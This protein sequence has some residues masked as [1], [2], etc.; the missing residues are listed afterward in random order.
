MSSAGAKKEMEMD[1]YE[2]YRLTRIVNGCGKMTKLAGAIVLPEIREVVNAAMAGFFDIEEV[3]A[4]AGEVIAKAT[5]AEWGCVTAC[6]AS[7][8]A[9][10]VAAAM[11][12][13]DAGRVAQL[14]DATGMKN[15]VVLQKGH[16]VNFGAPITQ[17]VRLAGAEAVEVG[18]VNGASE[19]LISHA[20]DDQTAAVLFVVSHHTVQFGC[21]PL[22]R[23]VALAHERGVPVIVD[24]AAQS[25]LI[26]EIVATGADLVI[27]S[28]HKYLSGTTAGIVCGR[29]DLVSAVNLQNRGIG[30][31]MKVGKEG[32][33]G[34]IAALEYRMRLDV[35]GWQ[36][37]QDRKMRM[38][39][40][41]LAGIEGVSLSVA[42]DPN[43]NP[44]SRARVDVDPVR[45][46]LSAEA[47]SRA[48]ADGDP[49]IH[50]R[51]HHT[52]E[53]FFMVDTIEMT[54]DEVDLTC[55]RLRSILTASDKT[56]LMTRYGGDASPDARAWLR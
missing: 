28:G 6:T 20:I 18:T 25:F 13:Q 12:G 1:L 37:E 3:Q 19:A 31:A 22:E 14:P 43:G 53:G 35:A 34:V 41:A 46:G 54:D 56:A 29:R 44:F 48:M 16:A 8:I 47:I 9:L 7:G 15:R 21:V 55:R 27:C 32:I 40:D 38:V 2:K 33:F 50:L 23:V 51:A 52:D 49:A 10:G 30:R 26:R 45:M 24:G 42:H 17:M 36:A 5:G 39:L 11:T 4:R